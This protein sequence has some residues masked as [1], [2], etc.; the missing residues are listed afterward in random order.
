MWYSSSVMS[1]AVLVMLGVSTSLGGLSSGV[2]PLQAE[3]P[4][5]KRRVG[6]A[7]RLGVG[8]RRTDAAAMLGSAV[9]AM[10][11]PCRL[12]HATRAS[13]EALERAMMGVQNQIVAKSVI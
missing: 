3:L 11:V 10:C 6:V 1:A 2:M 5:K 9:R 8:F 12:R 4:E 7:W 13:L